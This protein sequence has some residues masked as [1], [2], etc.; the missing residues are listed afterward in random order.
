MKLCGQKRDAAN[1]EEVSKIT[2][3]GECEAQPNR[4]AIF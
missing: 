2:Q 3:Y 4:I 1:K